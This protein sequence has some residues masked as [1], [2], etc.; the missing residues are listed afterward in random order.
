MRIPFKKAGRAIRRAVARSLLTAAV[1]TAL[2]GLAGAGLSP[3]TVEAAEATPTVPFVL[4]NNS[5]LKQKLYVYIVGMEGSK[6]VYVKNAKGK[7]KAFT[8]QTSPKPFGF[9][10]TNK[11]TKLTLPQLQ[12][13]RIYFS[14]KKKL[15]L[16][17]SAANV[18]GVPAGWSSGDPNYNTLFDWTE[19][20]WVPDSDTR[21]TLGGNAT[22]VDMFGFATKITLKGLDGDYKTPVTKTSGFKNKRSRK[23]I[24]NRIWNAG[25]PWRKLI[26]GKKNNPKRVIAPYH[27]MISGVFPKNQLNGYINKVWSKY[28]SGGMTASPQNV[29]YHGRVTG[30]KLVFTKNTD[31]GT[32]FSFPKPTSQAAYEGAILPDPIPGNALVEQQARAIGALLQGAF[33]RTT[34]M[35]DGDLDSCKTSDFYKAQPVNMYAKA[36]HLPAIRG[37]AYAFGFDDTCSQSSY[38][39]VHNPKK[40]KI[41]I[42]PVK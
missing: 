33:M 18:P 20:T 13:M 15:R 25:N 1:T 5:K 19:F 8:E 36:I 22:Q 27:G 31:P 28:Q 11:K 21:S 6:W 42:L 40:L 2:L 38:I 4:V 34:L 32:S 17:V 10:V 35:R 39:G 26:V 23:Q 24:V 41:E 16:T 30:G 12:A 7:T 37:E 14:F 9:A 29:D 3:T